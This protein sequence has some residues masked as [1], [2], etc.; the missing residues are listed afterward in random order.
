MR[1]ASQ[2][3]LRAAGFAIEAQPE[4]EVYMCRTV[5]P[6]SIRGTLD[7]P[8]VYPAAGSAKKQATEVNTK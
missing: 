4:P 3:M 7:R 5:A 1:H 8:V 6:G 2:A